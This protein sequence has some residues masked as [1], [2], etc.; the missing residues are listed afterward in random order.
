VTGED[1]NNDLPEMNFLRTELAFSA[2][3]LIPGVMGGL[4]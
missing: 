2:G 4:S 3:V 1:D